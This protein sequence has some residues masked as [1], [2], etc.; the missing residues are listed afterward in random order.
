MDSMIDC[1]CGHSIAWHA[2][3]GCADDHC[4]CRLNR[5]DVLEAAIAAVRRELAASAPFEVY[6]TA[7]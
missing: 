7:E 6:A 5:N 1:P 4:R 3:A 2:H